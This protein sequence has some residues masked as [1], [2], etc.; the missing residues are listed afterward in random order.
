MTIEL[1]CKVAAEKISENTNNIQSKIDWH[2]LSDLVL[3]DYKCLSEN[4]LNE[5]H[6]PSNTIICSNTQCTLE[7]HKNALDDYYES[8]ITA[9]QT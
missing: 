3:N 4:E 8:I 7:S 1:N 9:I 5:I 6:I 2:A